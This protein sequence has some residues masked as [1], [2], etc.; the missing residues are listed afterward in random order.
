MAIEFETQ[1]LNIQPEEIKSK[2]RQLGALETPEI[3]QKKIYF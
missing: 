2:L 3:L 1:I